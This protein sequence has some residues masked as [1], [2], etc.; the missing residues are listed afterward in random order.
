M[1]LVLKDYDETYD[2]NN[3]IEDET[4]LV[5]KLV[6]KNQPAISVHAATSAMSPVDKARWMY[7]IQ[8]AVTRIVVIPTNVSPKIPTDTP[9]VVNFDVRELV[10]ASRRSGVKPL[11]TSSAEWA[12]ITNLPQIFG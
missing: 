5:N 1:W 12:R 8:K 6:E 11:F 4:L 3:L 2:T 9:K 10:T 7:M